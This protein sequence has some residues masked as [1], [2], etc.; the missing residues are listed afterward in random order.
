MLGTMWGGEV[1]ENEVGDKRQ[2]LSWPACVLFILR[3]LFKNVPID[4]DLFGMPVD[5]TRPFSGSGNA[6]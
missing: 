4:F 5:V 6:G 3:F 2:R 1:R